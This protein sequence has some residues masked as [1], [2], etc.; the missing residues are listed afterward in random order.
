MYLRSFNSAHSVQQLCF[1]WITA[2]RTC[3][4]FLLMAAIQLSSRALVNNAQRAWFNVV[5]PSW[6]RRSRDCGT[7]PQGTA[8]HYF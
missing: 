4:A 2:L 7:T 5:Q 6:L 8:L 3:S 1:F